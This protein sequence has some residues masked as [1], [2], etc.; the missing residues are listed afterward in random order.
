MWLVELHEKH[1]QMHHDKISK[2]YHIDKYYFIS[3]EKMIFSKNLRRRMVFFYII[4]NFFII[5][6]I[7]F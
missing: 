1:W 4:A 5:I 3:V 7:T 6:I 2:L